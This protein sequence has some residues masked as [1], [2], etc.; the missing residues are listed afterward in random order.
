MRIA[1]SVL[2]VLC[3]AT[4]VPAQGLLGTEKDTAYEYFADLAA[5]YNDLPKDRAVYSR[6]VKKIIDKYGVGIKTDMIY[7][8]IRRGKDS[9]FAS[10]LL[11][12]R[13]DEGVDLVYRGWDQTLVTEGRRYHR[14]GKLKKSAHNTDEPVETAKA[15]SK[16]KYLVKT[17][18]IYYSP[19]ARSEEVFG[20]YVTTE[21]AMDLF[22]KLDLESATFTDRKLLVTTWKFNLLQYRIEFDPKVGGRP[23]RFDRFGLEKEGVRPLTTAITVEWDKWK[24]T[25]SEDSCWI[26]TK[27]QKVTDEFPEQYSDSRGKNQWLD[28]TE[29]EFKLPMPED[30][31]WLGPI[32]SLFGED[33]DLQYRFG[34]GDQSKPPADLE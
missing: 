27:F 17:C 11:N 16:I 10:G 13:D 32:E 25:G 23:T 19:I 4:I 22:K 34:V 18:E 33:W 20:G 30:D 31:D 1:F 24:R 3:F 15:D 2:I 14:L 28:L 21:Y 9:F 29:S 6:I 8:D 12:R 26:P 7:I 5:S